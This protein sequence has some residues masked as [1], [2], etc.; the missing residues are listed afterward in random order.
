MCN[1]VIKIYIKVCFTRILAN[2]MHIE[3]T[4]ILCIIMLLYNNYEHFGFLILLKYDL[5][6]KIKGHEPMIL[7][8]N[9]TNN[10]SI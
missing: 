3:N 6:N 1:E 9:Y 4:I 5:N 8:A 7:F 10:E 2:N